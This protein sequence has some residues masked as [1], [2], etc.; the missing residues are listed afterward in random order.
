MSIIYKINSVFKKKTLVEKSATIS[1]AVI[2]AKEHNIDLN[3]FLLR[4]HRIVAG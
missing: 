4:F 3:E 2:F 1:N